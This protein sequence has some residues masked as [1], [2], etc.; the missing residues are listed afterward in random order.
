M[1]T[2]AAPQTGQR[3]KFGNARLETKTRHGRSRACVQSRGD[4]R[5]SFVEGVIVNF[6][7]GA[8][9]KIH[10]E[11]SEY[12]YLSA[13]Q[14]NPLDS[15]MRLTIFAIFASIIVLRN[16]ILCSQVRPLHGLLRAPK[17][18]IRYHFRL[19]RRA[20]CWRV[21]F[22]DSSRGPDSK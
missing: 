6:I 4:G 19:T 12:G 8:Q 22:A 14:Y 17:W 10:D 2:A 15:A 16:S 5:V 20:P 1:L 11:Q 18:L 13:T 7:S 9:Q 3:S 21:V